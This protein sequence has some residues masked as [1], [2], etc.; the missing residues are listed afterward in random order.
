MSV[1][2][3]RL[4]PAAPYRSFPTPAWLLIAILSAPYCAVA[5]QSASE[6]RT[7]L[8]EVQA[9]LEAAERA[10]QQEQWA[11][12]ELWLERVI[13]LQPDHLRASQEW[14]QLLIRRGEVEA[15]RALLESLQGESGMPA[16][17]RRRPQAQL[18]PAPVGTLH[19][20]APLSSPSGIP[21]T[22]PASI[23][24]PI[25]R[26]NP[27]SPWRNSAEALIGHSHNP[28]VQPAS[29]EVVL[30]LPQGNLV[31]PL[32]SA[33][34]PGSV[35]GLRAMASH[36]PRGV[37]IQG[38][39]QGV[40]G[41]RDPSVRLGGLWSAGPQ[42]G[43]FTQAHRLAEGSRRVQAGVQWAQL[44][45][46]HSSG[47]GAES[48]QALLFQLSGY[49]EPGAN[50]LG[51]AGRVTLVTK[52]ASAWQ[53]LQWVERET[54]GQADGPP[55]SRGAGLMIDYQPQKSISI[56]VQVLD[57]KDDRGFSPLL[58]S[59]APRRLVTTYGQLE[60]ALGQAIERGPVLRV[61]AGRR[62]SNL[63]LFAWADAGAALMWRA[64][65]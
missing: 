17:L 38:Q 50:R 37:V 49:A 30:T 5:S 22:R 64:A 18:A 42:W 48:R 9:A 51:V 8:S 52:W 32:I 7:A 54:N 46:T 36:A 6:A 16:T 33:A 56:S 55:G 2:P 43:L 59:N 21:A 34:Q 10:L 13:M 24:H 23:A 47:G 41:Q 58:N 35:W 45:G 25:S 57:Q 29:Q 61:Q 65:W 39:I 19:S 26:E 40:A 3:G 53:T 28:L 20:S 27:P 62:L 12:A 1:L 11:L 31:L 60:V 15:G 4:G 63:P 14:A 44:L